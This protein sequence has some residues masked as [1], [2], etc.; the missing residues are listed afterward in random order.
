MCGII[1]YKAYN[2]KEDAGSI[3]LEG[4]KNLEYRGYDSWGIATICHGKLSVVKKIGK[5]SE[6]N[7]VEFP[8]CKIAIGH[9]RWAT[10]GGVTEKNAHP[11]LDC[12]G[13]IAVVHNGIV[14][15]YQELKKE[16]SS[17][18][19]VSETDTEVISHLIEENIGLGFEEAVKK[20]AGLLQGRSGFVAL[21]SKTGQIVAVRKGSPL[22]V[23]VGD[24]ETFIASDV[25]A[26]L[27]HT[28]KVMYIDD[29]EMAVLNDRVTFYNL[30]TGNEVE[31]RIIGI[32][33]QPGKAD[34]CG[35]EHFL[36]KEIMEQKNTIKDALN[37]DDVKIMKVADAI[38]HA[39]GTFLV[40]CGTAGKV[41]Q[42]GEYFFSH[43]AKKHV[44][45]CVAS[46]FPNYEEYLTDKTLM[47]A[48]SQSGETADVLEAID[49]AKKKNAKVISLLNVFGSTMMRLSD[50][51]FMINAGV[52]RAVVSTKAT[53]AQLAV[54]MLLAYA[55]AGKLQ[56]GKL[57]L[58]NA[59]SAVND[60]L[61][62]RYEDHIKVLAEKMR[63]AKAACVIGRSVNYPMAA[64]AAIKLMETDYIHAQGFAGGE[65]KH[66]PIALIEKGVPCIALVAND[67]TKQ[68][69]L[70][71][72]MEVKSRGG[73]IIG[74]SPENNEIFDYWIKVPDVG[75]ASP[76]V[77]IIPIQ[78][79]AYHIAVLKGLDP[80]KP[81]NLAKSVT[82]K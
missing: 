31:K 75:I 14:E 34:K 8:N 58:L 54:L 52:E 48:V 4:L 61:N 11:H 59:A 43:I 16:L 72:A 28:N 25:T 21:S 60:M 69:I 32:D 63:D 22:I 50:D 42:T 17:H 64:E 9:T 68:E 18:K 62:P 76:I 12:T 23:G 2:G 1:A 24:K 46:E 40:G 79:L 45:Y 80:D 81:R 51:C 3:V 53:T 20:A 47:I 33:W 6:A 73:Y 29:G 71:N 70:S 15:N 77:N 27:E 39:Y 30:S 26:F 44:N 13:T 74:V 38:N 35:R 5:I 19:F 41:C 7:H 57:L 10:H 37:Q 65:L 67:E 78:I 56:E 66:G 49:S 36:I 82:V 55:T